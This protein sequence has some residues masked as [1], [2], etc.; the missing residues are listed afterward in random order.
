[1]SAPISDVVEVVVTAESA[2]AQA[3]GF[4]TAMVLATHL[5]FAER[6]RA[7]G[8]TADM[9]A[10]GF[11]TTD[12]AYLAAAAYFA[13][14]PAPNTIK[15]GRRRADAVNVT[16][17]VAN[18]FAYV[19]TINGVAYTY[20]SDA[21]ATEQE[22]VTGLIAAIAASAVTGTDGGANIVTVTAKVAGTPFS[23]AVGANMTVGNA[24]AAETVTA[25]LDAQLTYDSD[26]YGLVLCD[27]DSASAQLAAAWVSANKRVLFTATA[28][29]DVINVV[30]G[31][32]TATLPAI[33]KA[34]GYDRTLCLY[35]ASAA[36]NFI[37]AAA[38]GWVLSKDPGTYTFALKTL[39]GITVSALTVAQRA[40]ALAKR[41]VT[42]ETRG[43][44]NQ[45]SNGKMASGKNVDQIH[46][47]DWMSSVIQANIFGLLSGV[48]KVPYTDPGIG[49]VEQQARS[50]GNFGVARGY[51]AS[52]ET[53]F[54]TLA[55]ISPADKA[56]RVLDGAS[57][58]A[59]E[60][61]AIESV[62]TFNL[63]VQV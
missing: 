31:S 7:Y 2:S 40:N 35:H 42:Y 21:D 36:T 45:T 62:I 53:D 57:M 46:G 56:A 60:A 51:L 22:I 3:A 41:C 16:I 13:Q 9:A 12:P 33:L 59:V 29:A 43:T 26:F 24:T 54:P 30:A 20:T 17:V 49:L 11:L 63:I 10:D 27:R 4:G 19:M 38:A 25:A 52:Y 14:E 8:S 1:M 5:H 61:G 55:E 15:I 23:L 18:A 44:F 58:T 47:R 32:D 34:S 37:D 50:A 6:S 48:N 28:E 39:I